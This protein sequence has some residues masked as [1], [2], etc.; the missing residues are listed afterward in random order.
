M[1][2]LVKPMGPIRVWFVFLVAVLAVCH[3]YIACNAGNISYVVFKRVFWQHRR[4]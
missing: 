4:S 3:M 2:R 1:M